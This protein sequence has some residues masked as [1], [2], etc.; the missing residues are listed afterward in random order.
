M[1]LTSGAYHP[2]AHRRKRPLK[3]KNLQGES[4][5]L[6]FVNLQYRILYY[7]FSLIA[8]TSLISAQFVLTTMPV[9]F[10]VVDP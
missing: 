4:G 9:E 1:V 7:I 5:G 10:P 8:L 2:L 3:P 6:N